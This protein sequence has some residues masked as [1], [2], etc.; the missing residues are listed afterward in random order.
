MPAEQGSLVGDSCD[1]YEFVAAVFQMAI[2]CFMQSG[3]LV[4]VPQ[5]GAGHR[6]HSK[7]VVRLIPG[8]NSGCSL[9]SPVGGLSCLLC[10]VD[11]SAATPVKSPGERFNED[12]MKMFI[13]TVAVKLNIFD[14]TA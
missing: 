4:I 5:S 13:D 9:G 3:P 6:T 7:S 11:E 14:D 8:V 1:C 12:N 10:V 2:R